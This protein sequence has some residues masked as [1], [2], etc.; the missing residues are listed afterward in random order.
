MFF[1]RTPHKSNG[2]WR[3]PF[4]DC[5][6]V[7][8]CSLF[9]VASIVGG[10][11]EW[12]LCLERSKKEG[13]DQESIQSSTTPDPGYLNAVQDIEDIQG[14]EKWKKIVHT[15][16]RIGIIRA[17]NESVGR[18]FKAATQHRQNNSDNQRKKEGKDQES[19]QSST[20]PDPGYLNAVRDIETEK[21][22][23]GFTDC[24]GCNFII[25]NTILNRFAADCML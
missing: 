2:C 8:V 25:L 14:K 24:L 11:G 13:K 9:T 3:Y 22:E 23:F 10:W 5:D 12:G 1:Q 4:Y 16:L 18:L 6:S 20:T 7:D 17:L 21:S 15:I 19:I